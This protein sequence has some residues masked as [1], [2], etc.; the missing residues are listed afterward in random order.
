MGFSCF[1]QAIDLRA[2]GDTL[3]DITEHPAFAPNREGP[4][5]ILSAA[6]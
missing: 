2:R 3:W 1:D 4:D 5:D 6:I